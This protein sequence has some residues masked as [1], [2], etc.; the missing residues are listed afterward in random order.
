MMKHFLLS[1]TLFLVGCMAVQGVPA[2]KGVVNFQQPDGSFVD[3]LIHGDESSKCITDLDGNI[4]ISDVDGRL[5]RASAEEIQIR[6][7]AAKAAPRRSVGLFPDAKFPT[8]GSPRALVILVE[9]ADVKFNL[10][11][12]HSYF[13][14]LLHQEGFSDYGGTGCVDEWFATN[15]YGQFTPAFDL[16]GPVTLEG[17]REYYG[18]NDAGGNDRYPH[19][20]VIEACRQLDAAVDFSQYDT[21][22]DGLIDNVFIF[23]AGQGENRSGIADAVWPHSSQITVLDKIPHVHDGVRLDRYACTN[24]WLDN[25]PDGIGTFIHEF[26]HVMGL[27][28]LYDTRRGSMT[29]TPGSWSVLDYGPYNNNGRTPP[30]Y[31]SFERL[32]LGWIVPEELVAAD[33]SYA[34]AALNSNKAYICRNQATMDSQEECREYFLFEN[35][36]QEGW[37][38]FLPGHG[39]L[40]WR[41][42]FD[43]EVWLGRSVNNDEHHQHVDLLEADCLQTILSKGGDSFPG[44]AGITSFTPNTNPAFRFLD[45]TSAGIEISGI[46]EYIDGL[47][48][49]RTGEGSQRPGKVSEVSASEVSSY[50]VTLEWRP[51]EGISNY[52]IYGW[53]ESADGDDPSALTSVFAELKVGSEPKFEISNL[54][55]ATKYSFRISAFDGVEEGELSDEVKVETGQ[56]LVDYYQAEI[57]GIQDISESGFKV[58]F[59]SIPCA[60]DYLLTIAECQVGEPFEETVD[61][62]DGLA[63]LPDGWEST[64]RLTYANAAYSGSQAG[65]L[66]MSTNGDHISSCIYDAPIYTLS[67]W[68]RGSSTSDDD[69][70][71]LETLNNDEWAEVARYA[72]E[73]QAGGRTET[74][75]FDNPEV[76]AMRIVFLRNS[77]KGSVAIDD[78]ALTWG[79]EEMSLPLGEWTERSVGFFSPASVSGLSPDTTYELTLTATDGNLR[80]RTSDPVRVTTSEGSGISLIQ[81]NAESGDG[82]WYDLL[83]RPIKMPRK[84][85]IYVQPQKGLQCHE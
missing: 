40:V 48:T 24:E 45:G 75:C 21:D 26:S 33:K 84:G 56:P 52:L 28:D 41:V 74:F 68:S 35:R 51:V 78:I 5:R 55:P 36:Q 27:P 83:G 16:Y 76:R 47:V 54:E 70:L 39:M 30:L 53:K 58:E 49:F 12:P 61:F 81:N 14:N 15:S 73:R 13:N 82:S 29:Y 6:E 3:I 7:Q 79:G 37:D 46:R 19:L 71:I 17:K 18:G 65:A 34:L 4:L 72:I 59:K 25:E 10:S 8:Q 38:A 60:T 77:E 64:S 57:T 23:Y 67:F 32:A 1:F 11:D 31:S 66:R 69:R 85:E 44:S 80:S 20:M 43:P 9:Y 42:D 63:S 2:Y 50:G 22:G 62:S